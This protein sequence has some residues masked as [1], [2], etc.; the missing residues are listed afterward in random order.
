MTNWPVAPFGRETY[1]VFESRLPYK[2]KGVMAEWLMRGTVNTFF[3]GSIPL[4]TLNLKTKKV[5]FIEAVAPAPPA[6]PSEGGWRSPA[7]RQTAAAR[8]D[9]L[10]CS[11]L[12]V[13]PPPR[14]VIK[15]KICFNKKTKG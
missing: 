2:N 5:K 6:P 10:A 14:L 15:I 9:S 12:S 4:D 13:A 3:R 11:A 7:A 1:S 8:R